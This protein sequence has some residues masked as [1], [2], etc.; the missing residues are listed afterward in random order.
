MQSMV[1][2]HIDSVQDKIL[3]GVVSVDMHCM[4]A[5]WVHQGHS[6]TEK[7]TCCMNIA[8]SVH[9]GIT[10]VIQIPIGHT[11]SQKWHFVLLL[12]DACP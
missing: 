8:R 4:T 2:N 3:W 5:K 10:V 6:D 11:N 7:Q 9:S 12:H 1:P